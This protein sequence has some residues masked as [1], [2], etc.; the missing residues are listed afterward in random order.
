M[1]SCHN[2]GENVYFLFFVGI[3]KKDCYFRKPTKRNQFVQITKIGSKI[4]SLVFEDDY[5]SIY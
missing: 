4:T 5:K 1:L 2:I 3:I